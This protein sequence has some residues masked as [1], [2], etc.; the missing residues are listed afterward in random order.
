M[1]WACEASLLVLLASS[2]AVSSA[3]DALAQGAA[4]AEPSHG[5][6]DGDLTV[7]VGA[8]ATVVP[9]GVRPEGELRLRYL[10]TAGLFTTY[11][12]AALFQGAAAEPQ[13]V[14]ALGG[15]L[16]P[17][18]LGRWLTGYETRRV[19]LDLAL[20]SLGLEL[21]AV[22]AQRPGGPFGSDLGLQLG[23]GLELPLLE[24]P[25]GPWIGL[26]GGVRWSD[27]SLASGVVHGAADRAAFLAVTLAW[28][29]LVV[30]HL[31]DV[32]DQAP[33]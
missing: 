21:A 32:G 10:E 1:R 26:H 15:E 7:V 31:V 27:A 22:F 12:E 5:R 29:E 23:L 4:S 13:R 2:A 3:R 18:F 20:D 24:Q 19:R 30:A 6:V 8:G 33:R 14:L 25:S 28:H 16:R 17:L 11:E 9:Q